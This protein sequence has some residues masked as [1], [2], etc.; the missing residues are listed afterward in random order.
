[1]DV[2]E[3]V[4]W[5]RQ[6]ESKIELAIVQEEVIKRLHELEHKDTPPTGYQPVTV[7]GAKRQP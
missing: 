6:C 7:P 2:L 5:A 1:M 4:H 3:V